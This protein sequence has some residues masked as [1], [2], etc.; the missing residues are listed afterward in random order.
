[1]RITG[2]LSAVL[3]LLAAPL[4]AQEPPAR[5]G[6]AELVDGVVAIVGDTV[7]LLSDVQAEM[8]NLEASGQPVPTEPGAREQ[9]ARE[10]IQSRV[11]DLILLEA[12]QDAGIS[13][14]DA[15]VQQLVEQD[16]RSVRRRFNDSEVALQQALA[17]SGLTIDDYRRQLAEQHRSRQMIEGF[18]AVRMRN[19]ARPLISEDQ[20]REYFESQRAGLG[21][22]PATASLQQAVIRPTPS[23]SARQAARLEA[24]Q[25]LVELARGGDF[26]VLARR[27]SDDVGTREHGGD[28]GWF[29]AGRMV[30]EFE[31]AAFALRPGQT[32]GIVETDFGFHI[33]RL[34]RVRGPERQARHILI[35]PELTPADHREAR[36]RADSVIT[37]VRDGAS[38]VRIAR[39]HDTPPSEIEIPRIPM[40]RLPPAYE[41]ALAGAA[42]GEVVG[43]I[44]L[45][46]PRG[47]SWAVLKVVDRQPAGE[48]TLEDVRQQIRGQ[49]EQQAMVEQLVDELRSELYVAVLQ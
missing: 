5:T 46:S 17:R 26:E 24:E 7:L 28:L 40:D 12:A 11:T 49:L 3:L 32:S 44:E 13:V 36:A 48:Y 35:Q 6:G 43:P 19:R 16:L 33:I 31:R 1:M 10:I 29:R 45:E 34:E 14:S 30:P 9:V 20:I 15:E 21:T 41:T 18:M 37:A 2:T 23:D 39:E 4:A 25:V 27:F 8:M 38:L 22:R 47:S 42:A